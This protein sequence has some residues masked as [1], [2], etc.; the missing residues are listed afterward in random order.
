[1][2]QTQ[3]KELLGAVKGE[4]TWESKAKSSKYTNKV[5]TVIKSGAKSD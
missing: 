4:T 3:V 5:C 2:E 1:M